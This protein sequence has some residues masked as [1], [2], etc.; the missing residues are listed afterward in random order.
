MNT[1]WMRP[2]AEDEM[3]SHEQFQP[4][5]HRRAETARLRLVHDDPPP[6]TLPW[7]TCIQPYSSVVVPRRAQLCSDSGDSAK[8][9]VANFISSGRLSGSG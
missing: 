3:T 7:A 6:I 2:R 1:T 4:D 5:T 9:V 8:L